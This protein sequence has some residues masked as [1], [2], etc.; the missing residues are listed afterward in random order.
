[1]TWKHVSVIL[2][3]GN[4]SGHDFAGDLT[5][6]EP[7]THAILVVLST[8]RQVEALPPHLDG[9]GVQVVIEPFK[10]AKLVRTMSAALENTKPTI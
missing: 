10:V 2:T 1:M 4:E 3:Q 5:T 6:M 7:R 9:M 8:V